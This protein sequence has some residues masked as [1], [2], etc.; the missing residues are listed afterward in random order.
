MKVG[1]MFGFAALTL[2]SVNSGAVQV[3][4]KPGLW[5]HSVKFDEKSLAAAQKEHQ[6]EIQQGIAEMK[7]RLADIP[8]EQRAQIAAIMKAN[9]GDLDSPDVGAMVQKLVPKEPMVSKECLTQAQINEGLMSSSQGNCKNQ[10]TQ[11]SGNTFKVVS[12]CKESAL[13]R[14]DEV[15]ITV[16]NQKLYTGKALF[17]S[18]KA[19]GTPMQATITGKWL[20]SDC[21]DIKP[22]SHDDDSEENEPLEEE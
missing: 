11:I 10:I 7:K 3:D 5:E 2:V 9:G 12:D 4:V 13:S 16:Q 6:Q 17:D 22:H 19:G 8:P 14:R 15:L 1:L 20:S 18:D 21:G